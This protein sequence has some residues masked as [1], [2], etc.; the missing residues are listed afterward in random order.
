MGHSKAGLVL[1]LEVQS[2]GWRRKGQELESLK[3]HSFTCLVVAAA[4][5]GGSV[6]TVSWSIHM[7]LLQVA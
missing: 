7:M 6:R 4:A 2:L 1:L 3:P 5:A